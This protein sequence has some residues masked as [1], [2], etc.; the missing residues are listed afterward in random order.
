MSA[1]KLNPKRLAAEFLVIFAG[2]TLSFLADDWRDYLADREEEEVV[3]QQVLADLVA[4]SADISS[5][6]RALVRQRESAPWLLVRWDSP[7]I[8]GDSVIARL[9][10]FTGGSRYSARRT[11]FVSLQS[12]G[13]LGVVLDQDLRLALTQYY[14][15]TQA[16]WAQSLDEHHREWAQLYDMLAS[17]LRLAPP[18]TDEAIYPFAPDGAYLVGGWNAVRRD[19]ALYNQIRSVGIRADI[20]TDGADRMLA[21]NAALR[22][23]VQRVLAR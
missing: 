19:I 22:A 6:R 1:R 14:E 15:T 13:G 12:A 2:V 5:T 16:E 17:H 3:L 23:D 9:V 8:N 4:D 7:E 21:G 18:A 10:P 20:S 11:A